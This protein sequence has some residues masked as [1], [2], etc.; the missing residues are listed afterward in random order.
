MDCWKNLQQSSWGYPTLILCMYGFF[1]TIR[2]SEPFLTPYLTGSYKNLTIDQVTNQIF[3]VWTYSYLVILFPV[4]L[5][6]DYLR[7]KPVILLQGA[8]YLITWLMLLFAQGVLAMQFVEVFYGMVTATDVA[9]YS[10][11]YSVVSP[12]HYQ[13]VTSYCRSVTLVGFTIGSVLGQ[14]LV[15]FAGVSYFH[16]NVISTVFVS[17]AIVASF[18]LPMPQTSMFF[19]RKA[20]REMSQPPTN[21]Q[22]QI[23][24]PN[25]N[26][27]EANKELHI[28]SETSMD[29]EYDKSHI[30]KNETFLFVKVILMLWADFKECYT[31]KEL[32]YW[33]IW[34]A[35]ATC[36]YNQIVNYVQVLWDH[37]E[38]SSNMTV[39]NGGV[40][41]VST[42]LGAGA[43]FAVGYVNTDWNL[44][45]ELSLG[46]FSAV[47]AGA[48]YLMDLTNNIWVCY[49]G[50]LI[51]KSSY[52]LLITIAT[53]QIASNLSMERYALMFGVNNF[54]ALALQT[55]LTVI[56]VDKSGLGLE[57]ITQFLVYGSYFAVIALIFL[58]RG[59]FIYT[60]HRCTKKKETSPVEPEMRF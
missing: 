33:S 12:D 24:P 5:A 21:D 31:S 48:L 35:M 13:R 41:A 54:I 19:H 10:Y 25:T 14:V 59:I 6:T 8:S 23:S 22:N 49:A 57:I 36:G 11:I 27:N 28:P 40:E 45:G 58:I 4:F 16:L 51:F 46:I 2:P 53:F 60:H 34:W 32:L 18:F 29:S 17:V 47:D 15:S 38:P 37:I 50:Y 3:P 42:L 30:K 56:V 9:Y 20:T 39:Y 55:I 26:I 44:W 52:M 43:S 7:Y 1:S